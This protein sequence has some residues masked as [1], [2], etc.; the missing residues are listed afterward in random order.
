MTAIIILNAVFSVF[1][2]VGILALLG[3]GIATDRVSAARL[4]RRRRARAQAARRFNP[5]F[6]LR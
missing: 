1:V 6:D 4:T 5:A 2:V 3:W